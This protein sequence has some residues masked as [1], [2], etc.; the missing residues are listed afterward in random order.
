MRRVDFWFDPI[1]PYAWLA[2]DA[3]P[4]ALEGLTVEVRYRPVL[5]A[6]LLVHWGQ[7][8][9]AEIGPKRVWTYRD[10]AWRAHRQ[11]LRLEVPDPHPFNPLALLRLL[12][13]SA[14]P[15]ETPSRYAVECVFRHVWEGGGDPLQADRL[16]ALTEALQP[17]RDPADPAVKAELRESTEQAIACQLFG[18]PTIVV[19]G[20]PFWGAD[21]L[22]A[23]SACLR[24]D[25]WFDG[26]AW[27]EAART[28]G[29]VTRR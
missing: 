23:V 29:A 19:D 16:A 1:S 21:A 22:D 6:G 17:L 20:K 28:R 3:L 15:G 2:F 14:A 12:V 24:G 8:G 7:K 18:V 27:A 25:A 11:G 10:V 5:F 9:P 4:D 13:A 26:P